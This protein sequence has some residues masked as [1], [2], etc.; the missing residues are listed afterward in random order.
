MDRRV[1]GEQA[2]SEALPGPLTE[3]LT[4]RAEQ[5]RALADRHKN[6]R[7]QP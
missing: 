7:I 3:R 1:T 2:T 5:L 6:D 4:R